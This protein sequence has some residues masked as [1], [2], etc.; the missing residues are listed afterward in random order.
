MTERKG[1]PLQERARKLVKFKQRM[2]FA[3][4]LHNR[5]LSPLKDPQKVHDVFDAMEGGKSMEQVLKMIDDGKIGKSLAAVVA[6]L[7]KADD[8][9]STPSHCRRRRGQSGTTRATAAS[10]ARGRRRRGTAARQRARARDATRRRHS[11]AALANRKIAKATT[12][13]VE[14]LLK[15]VNRR[16]SAGRVGRDFKNRSMPI[17]CHQS[18]P[19]CSRLDQNACS[20][21]SMIA[22]PVSTGPLSIEE[23]LTFD[24]RS[25]SRRRSPASNLSTGESAGSVGR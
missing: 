19:S 1:E 24:Q 5:G 2:K 18:P 11:A 12:Q 23:T 25:S 21:S 15:A 3:E 14:H 4:E 8:I 6:A 17:L 20:S 22:E 9:S 7:Q 10:T 16:F 13:V